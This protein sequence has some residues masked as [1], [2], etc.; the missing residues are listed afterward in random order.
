[1]SLDAVVVMAKA[2]EAFKVKTRLT[3]PLDPET[4]SHLYHCFL[5]DKLEQV[6]SLE[7]I[8]PVVAYTPYNSTDFF[9]GIQPAGFTMLPQTGGDLGER[10]ANISRYF[11]EQGYDKVVLLDSDSPNLP[12]EYIYD[13]L[14]SL[15]TVDAVIGPCIDGGYYL[16]GLNKQ[17]SGLFQ[18]I[19]WSTSMVTK[20]TIE[21]A[22]NMGITISLLNEWYDVDTGEDLLRLKK[23]LENPQD[24]SFVCKNTCRMLFGI[25]QGSN[26]D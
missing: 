25:F 18:D 13:S 19:P 4:A 14:R 17:K 26:N 22:V 12:S 1:M 11:F 15:N 9:K 10:L 23:D 7:G 21:K 16:I 20:S 8:S 5:L 6:R 24:G 2:P 3:P